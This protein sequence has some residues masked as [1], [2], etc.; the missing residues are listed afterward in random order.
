MN[1]LPAATAYRPPCFL[2]SVAAALTLDGY[3]Q[4]APTVKSPTQGPNLLA[5]SERKGLAAL[6]HNLRTFPSVSSPR[7]TVRKIL[8]YATES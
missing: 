8:Y 7:K 2:A 5:R 1:K 6:P 3:T 4:T